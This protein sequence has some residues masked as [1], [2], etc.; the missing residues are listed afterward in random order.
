[1][2]STHQLQAVNSLTR[3]LDARQLAW[4]SGYLTGLQNTPAIPL[5]PGIPAP[6]TAQP[7]AAAATILYGSHG[8]NGKGVAEALV[9]AVASRGLTAHSVSMADYKPARLKK[10]KFLFIVIST[11]GE[12][13][14]PDSAKLF[15][16]FLFSARAPK[17]PDLQY[18]VLALGDSSYTYFCQTG[19][20]MD[21]RLAALGATAIA[22]RVEC[23]VDFERAAE[24]WTKNMTALYAEQTR[25]DDNNN[26]DLLNG[27][28][29]MNGFNKLDG[30]LNGSFIN[31]TAMPATL[32]Y[33]RKNPFPAEVLDTIVL[34]RPPRHT[35]HMELSLEGSGLVYQPGDSIGIL[36]ENSPA[37]AR[38]TA[39]ALQ[40]EWDDNITLDDETASAGEWLLRRLDISQPTVLALTRYADLVAANGG[41]DK[42]LAALTA[43]KAA[44]TA[45]LNGRSF[46]D[47]FADFPPPAATAAAVLG[48]LRRLAPRL[49]S[50]ASSA[51]GRGDEAHILVGVEEFA[52]ADNGIRTGLCSDY[53]QQRQTG[54]VLRVFLQDNDAFRLPTNGDTPIIM[55]GPGTGVAPF[56]AFMEER[57]ERGDRSDAWL[58]FGERNRRDDFYYQNE[59]QAYLKSGV[60]SRLDVAFSRDQAEKIYV[61]H[62]LRQRGADVWQW[63]QNGAHFYVCGDEG[64]M[65]KDVHAEL[66]TIIEQ[67]GGTNSGSGED[68]L[69]QMLADGRYQRDVY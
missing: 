63:L 65:A 25:D 7:Q 47:V 46:A 22:P 58:F 20:E 68:Y 11:H 30:I 8:G 48:C 28:N 1:M 35:L 12:G 29:G 23:D 52:A 42:K 33:N 15:Y 36:P 3:E 41:G 60:L 27:V 54:D 2:L 62:K 19:Q 40:L 4:L 50:L 10:E 51:A 9:A 55:V 14:P 59:W 18:A 56:R 16:D 69:R 66:V 43:D 34:T 31:A 13:E 44:A 21:E 67:H 5:A 17:L 6:A 64:S 45:Y 37:L 57:E 24:K 26:G 53:L 61:Q 38:Q 32:Q 49:Y 39:A